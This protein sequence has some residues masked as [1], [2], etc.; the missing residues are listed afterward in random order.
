MISPEKQTIENILS[1]TKVKYSVPNYQRSFDWGKSELQ[2]LMDDLKEIKESESK[3]L[4]LGNFIFDISDPTDYKIVDGQQRLT[5]ISIIFIALR[6][7]AKSLNESEMASEIQKFIS[8]YSKIRNKNVVKFGVSENIRDIYEHLTIPGWDG[9]F[10]T[11]LNGK[12]IKRQVN[13]VKPIYNYIKDTISYFNSDDLREFVNALWDTYVVVIKVENTEDVFSV[14]ERTNA[15]GLDLN[16]GDLLKNY[17]FSHQ[18]DSLEQKWSQIIDNSVGGLPRM[19]KYFWVSRRGYIQQSQLY[20]SLKKYVNEID[21]PDKT[22]INQF[23]D[24]LYTFSRY[25]HAA[26]SLDPYI[27]QEW[28]EEF[29]LTE[30]SKNEDYYHRVNRVFQALK[31]FRVTQAYPLIF[32]ILKAYKSSGSNPK[33]LFTVLETIEKYHFVNNVI[34]GRVG[35]EVEKF[36]AERA[37]IIYNTDNLNIEISILIQELTKKRALQDEFTSNFIDTLN[38]SQKNIALLNYV[39]DRINNYDKNQKSFV[40][41]SQYVSI[42]SPEKNLNKRNYNIEHLLPQDSK[43]KYKDE[44]IEKID[45]IGN[46]III[47]RH[48]NSEFGNKTPKEKVELITRDKKHFG[49]LRYID[50]FL[51]TYSD[52]FENWG[53]SEIEFRSLKFAETAYLNTWKF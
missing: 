39:F 3:E 51:E 47:S 17:I 6:E 16:I 9:E 20:K 38:Y 40:K 31:L 37:K 12:S 27:V 2:E 19:L 43:K 1:G 5:T 49:N 4:F 34:S 14:F 41:G 18:E 44:E 24:E 52:K 48:S 45:S 33:R 11:T 28:F 32:A 42:Y 15:R 21:S 10:P 30:I 22:G 36:Y 35:H 25:Y 53:L 50:E 13:K 26:Q 7:Q 8:I 29:E 46:L 23:I